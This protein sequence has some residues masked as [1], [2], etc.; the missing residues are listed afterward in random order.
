MDA[1]MDNITDNGT[2]ALGFLSLP[3]YL[4][5]SSV[6]LFAIM[7]P[8][9]ILNCINLISL[10]CHS[11]L[12]STVRMVLGALA[13]AGILNALGLIMQRLSGIILA[14]S[15]LP[16]PNLGACRFIL[17]IILTGAACRLTFLALFAIFVLVVVIAKPK[18]TRPIVFAVVFTVVFLVVCAVCAL[19]FAPSLTDVQYASGVSCSPLSVGLPTITFVIFYLLV[20]AI[21]PLCVSLVMPIIALCY[22]KKNT[23]TADVK[24]KKA[25]ARF[26]L[27]LLIGNVFNFIGIALP[28]ALAA[29]RTASSISMNGGVVEYL[30]YAMMSLSL[31]PSPI[32]MLIFFKAV[33]DGIIRIFCC[34]CRKK[35]VDFNVSRTKSVS[36]EST[37]DVELQA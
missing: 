33:R 14:S 35:T 1:I 9:A 3:G 15:L 12:L 23:I 21:V 5:Y 18:Y 28:A 19:V 27:F 26:T 10:L 11:S 4:A 20:F 37:K 29:Q 30:P 2:M 13:V 34:C 25:M 24:I 6:L 8:A 36:K 31:L 17:W 32:L 16:N 22:I 7:L